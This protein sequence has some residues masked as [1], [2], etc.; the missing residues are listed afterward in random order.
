MFGLRVRS[1][2]DLPEL[3]PLDT[4]AEP[5]VT[6]KVGSVPAPADARPGVHLQNGSLILV[7]PGVAI[8]SIEEGRAITVDPAPGVPKRNVRLYLLGSVFGLM[9]H[10]RGMLPLHA[11]AVEVKGKAVLFMGKSGAGKSTLAAWFQDRGRRVITDDVCV[12][13]F[14]EDGQPWVR[15]GVPRL[16]LWREVL[17]ATGRDVA[18][19]ER[20]FIGESAPDKYDVPFVDRHD[21]RLPLGA[22]YLLERADSLGIKRITGLA[23]LEAAFANT[24]RGSYVGKI[25]TSHAHWS[26]IVKLV[27]RTPMFRAERCWGLD[28]LDDQSA[29]LLSHAEE[30]LANGSESRCA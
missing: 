26:A 4:A 19:Y 21:I 23:A 6:V 17:T 24:Y 14:A 8:Y 15:T 25:G 12:I 1:E 5:D 22:I 2:L 16:R 7:T 29:S 10:Q 11:N 30:I 28:E 3:C 13:E 9:L 18:D 20:S 27:R